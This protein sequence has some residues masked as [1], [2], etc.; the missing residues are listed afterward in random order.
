M[1]TGYG[2]SVAGNTKSSQQFDVIV[3]TVFIVVIF[4]SSLSRFSSR[5]GIA[6]K[7]EMTIPSPSTAS[8]NF[9]S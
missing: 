1:I 5:E 3:N 6:P 8:T 7:H 2:F 4:M 9:A